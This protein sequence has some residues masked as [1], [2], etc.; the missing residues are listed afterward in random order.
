MNPIGGLHVYGDLQSG[1]HPGGESGN[2]CGQGCARIV[3]ESDGSGT[4]GLRFLGS[5]EE[6]LLIGTG[7]VQGGEFHLGTQCLGGTDQ[8]ADLCEHLIGFHM[9][10]IFHLQGGNGHLDLQPG[11][12]RVLHAFPGPGNVL[13][14]KSHGDRKSGT[15]HVFRDGFINDR[16]L[17]H[18]LYGRKLHGVRTQR[19]RAGGDGRLF[20]EQKGN[21][22]FFTEFFQCRVRYVDLF[23]FFY[24]IV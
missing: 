19:I 9:I 10:G 11:T 13:L 15:A 21:V 18:V 12:S 4:A 6:E 2:L 16:I 23:H 17:P 7:G 20:P 24:L 3:T 1:L 22:P 5:G 8:G 14:R